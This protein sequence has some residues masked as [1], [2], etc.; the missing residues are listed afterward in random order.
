[1]KV[2]LHIIIFVSLFLLVGCSQTSSEDEEKELHL[3]A[4]S[5][6]SAPLNEIKEKYEKENDDM[7]LIINYGSSGT[8]V[9][10]L[11][12]GAP[13][14]IIILASSFWMEQAI[15]QN[16][17]KQ[18]NVIDVFTNQLVLASHQDSG[19]TGLEGLAEEKVEKIAVGDP[20][21]VPVGSYTKQ[22]LMELEYWELLEEK[23]VLAKSARQVAAYIDSKNVT[24]GFVFQSDLEAFPALQSVETISDSLHD[25]IIYPAALTERNAVLEESEDFLTFLESPES[26]SIFQKYG[27]EEIR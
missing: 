22:A 18:E 17:V 5:S 12:Q 2:K 19:L 9:N 6:L 10:Q 23:V 24:A 16:L 15:E 7:K 26:V 14:D 1:M 11:G 4:A 27:F 8:L 21:S 13:V 20:D 3:S 25:P